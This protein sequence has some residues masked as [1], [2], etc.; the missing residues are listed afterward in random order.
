MS[1]APQQKP[2]SDPSRPPDLFTKRPKLDPA[3]AREYRRQGRLLI[4]VA[5]LFGLMAIVLL[6]FSAISPDL[7]KAAGPLIA[8]I[9]ILAMA[10]SLAALV[11]GI[12]R[13]CQSAG[14]N[15]GCVA[16]L[17]IFVGGILVI[18]MVY[19]VVWYFLLRKPEGLAP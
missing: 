10:G 5:L 14:A 17:A 16:V 19:Q 15:Q 1:N 8:V 6:G 12:I 3:K 9:S 2:Q 18:G 11:A 4:G 13:L 7:G